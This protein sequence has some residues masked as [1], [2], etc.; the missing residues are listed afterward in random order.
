[1]VLTARCQRARQRWLLLLL[2]RWRC[3]VPPCQA[4]HCPCASSVVL[5]IIRR[6]SHHQLLLSVLLSHT[7]HAFVSSLP[8]LPHALSPAERQQCLTQCPN[9]V[10]WGLALA[11][12]TRLV[13]AKAGSFWHAAT[14][15]SNVDG[16]GVSCTD[17]CATAA[18]GE[19]D[20]DGFDEIDSEEKFKQAKPD[21]MSCPNGYR[22]IGNPVVPCTN[23]NGEC[24]YGTRGT[25]DASHSG[26][27][28]LCPCQCGAG[29]YQPSSAPARSCPRYV[30]IAVGG[31]QREP[32]F[33]APS[34]LRRNR[35]RAARWLPPC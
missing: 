29:S 34:T 35:S 33:H 19:C 12:G 23:S 16:F 25:C 27:L 2:L 10:A 14:G 26:A 28:R 4:T 30:P 8:S 24:Y 15:G 11:A 5:V 22:S 3:P 20:A 18:V 9:E 32:F 13:D 31:T 17:A 1:M 21:T 7:T 6:L